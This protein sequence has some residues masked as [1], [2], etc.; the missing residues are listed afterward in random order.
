MNRARL[1]RL[2]RAGLLCR[3]AA[4]VYARASTYARATP[5]EAFAL[6]TR[7]FVAACG[8][9]AYA[10][11]WSAAAIYGFP[12]LEP[13]PTVAVPVTAGR[14][15]T[16][17]YGR[18][19]ATKLPRHDRHIV[20]GCRVTSPGRTVVDIAR[21]SPTASALVV[22]D[23]A[24]AS[25]TSREQLD[26]AMA[27]ADGTPGAR[28]ASW[29]VRHADGHAES[30]LET[31]GRLTFLEAGL[32]VPVSN[33]WVRAGRHRYRPD[34]LLA[35]HWLVFE[36]DGAFKYDGRL[37]AGR[38][39]GRQ[40]EREW[41]LR[42]A[43]LQVVRYSWDMARF[44]RARLARRFRAAVEACPPRELPCPWTRT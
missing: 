42:E 33:P 44:D 4:G 43:G 19:Y 12:A 26:E 17:P 20:A 7:A 31:L 25:V 18:V 8:R 28:N 23:A 22:A 24:V 2:A 3:L 11:G 41:R 38:V 40:Q 35:R 13:P 27:R 16:S 37:D 29:V 32:P 14:G 6:R 15:Y 30:P 34:H 1:T 9:N 21:T 36:G 39:I 10:A 5:W